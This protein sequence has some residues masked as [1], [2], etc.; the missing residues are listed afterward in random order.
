MISNLTTITSNGHKYILFNME[1]RGQKV[2]ITNRMASDTVAPVVTEPFLRWVSNDLIITFDVTD[3]SGFIRDV[4][5]TLHT[6]TSDHEFDIVE[7]PI[8]WGN[9]TYGIVLF[10]APV[11]EMV[12]LVDTIDSNGNACSILFSIVP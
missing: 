6:S 10:D 1:P 12:M 9:S 7:N 4:N 8:F 5:V 2:T 11:E 3:L